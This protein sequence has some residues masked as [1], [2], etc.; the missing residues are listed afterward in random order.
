MRLSTSKGSVLGN[1]KSFDHCFF[2]FFFFEL[3]LVTFNEGYVDV[4]C[5]SWVRFEGGARRGGRSMSGGRLE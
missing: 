3:P 4:G 5:W 2:F 1:L